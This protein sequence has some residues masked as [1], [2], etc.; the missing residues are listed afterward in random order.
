[1]YTLG[2]E[3]K[4]FYLPGHTLSFNM[5]CKGQQSV[6]IVSLLLDSKFKRIPRVQLLHPSEI[7]FISHPQSC[8][9]SCAENQYIFS[10]VAELNP[11]DAR[12]SGSFLKWPEGTLSCS[13]F[14]RNFSSDLSYHSKLLQ[15]MDDLR[16][17]TVLE[18]SMSCPIFK[19]WKPDF[20][21]FHTFRCWNL[22]IPS[23][24]YGLATS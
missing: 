4:C 10:L 16:G 18:T 20:L 13:L 15:G 7:S 22:A 3:I 5:S 1:M 21:Q 9:L 23:V 17:V 12:E 19:D 11:V 8:Q 24:P 2:N 6:T 14:T